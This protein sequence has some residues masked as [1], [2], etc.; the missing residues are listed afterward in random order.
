[1]NSKNQG[2]AHREFIPA[3]SDHVHSFFVPV[4]FWIR[5][6][7]PVE[8]HLGS[9]QDAKSGCFNLIPYN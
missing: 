2:S 6:P 9:Q 7:G 3:G 8:N 5:V 4:N 1:M